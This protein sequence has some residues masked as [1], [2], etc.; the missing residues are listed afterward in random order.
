VL[1]LYQSHLDVSGPSPFLCQNH[2][3]VS[4]PSRIIKRFIRRNTRRDNGIISFSKLV[5]APYYV[6]NHYNRSKFGYWAF[7]HWGSSSDAF[8]S[9]NL[10]PENVYQE[11][12]DNLRLV[13]SFY[14][15]YTPPNLWLALASRK[16]KK[17]T[18]RLWFDEPE[19]AGAGALY[20]N[21]GILNLQESWKAKNSY[22]KTRCAVKYCRNRLV[23]LSARERQ[24]SL[25]KDVSKLCCHEHKFYQTILE[26]ESLE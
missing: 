23:G 10:K 21:N 13:L 7:E 8:L 3:E 6:K 12:N 19:S 17:L 1:D 4:G 16:Y 14:T 26:S 24:D 5:P 18:F 22:L 20:Y 15:H 11:S 25:G 9:F 2:L